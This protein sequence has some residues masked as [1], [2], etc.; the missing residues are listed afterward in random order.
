M[1]VQ[2]LL[3]QQY[4]NLCVKLGA[5]TNKKNEL[6]SQVKDVEAQIKALAAIAPEIKKM[7]TQLKAANV[8]AEKGD[9]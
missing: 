6:D 7:E 1:T 4:T 3:D 8:Q 2:D 9:N 5:L